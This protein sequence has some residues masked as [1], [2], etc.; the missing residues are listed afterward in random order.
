M[1]WITDGVRLDPA[2]FAGMR[3]VEVLYQLETPMIYTS[4]L[5][6]RLVLVYESAV[7]VSSSSLR[8]IVVPIDLKSLARLKTGEQTVLGVLDQPEVWAVTEDFD[9]DI[10]EARLL[11]NGIRSAP[12]D[13]KPAQGALLWPHLQSA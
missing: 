8:R 11:A 10:I 12:A 4:L 2:P 5:C 7:D 13:A 1:I 3:P 9:G 6:S